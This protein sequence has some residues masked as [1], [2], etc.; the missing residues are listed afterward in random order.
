MPRSFA[1]LLAILPIA[2]LAPARAQASCGWVTSVASWD[3]SLG[4]SWSNG[5]YSWSKPGGE[6]DSATTQDAGS[7][8]GSLAQA[9]PGDTHIVGVMTGSLS[10]FDRLDITPSSGESG[11]TQTVANGP[12]TGGYPLDPPTV[13]LVLDT[14]SCTYTWTFSVGAASTTTTNRGGGYSSTITPNLIQSGEWPI[15]ELPGPLEFDGAIHASTYPPPDNLTPWFNS[16]ANSA[17]IAE[18]N[19]YAPETPLPDASVHWSFRPGTSV[20]PDN[21]GCAGARFLFG[22]ENQDVSFATIAPTDPAST[23]GAGD[24][25]VWFFFLPWNSGT[26]QISTSGSG[27]STVVSVWPV[28][29]TCASLTTEVAC[30]AN[31]A[32]VPVQ[33]GVPLL[34]QVRRSAAGG[35]GSLTIQATPEP[36][37]AAAAGVACGGLA[38]LAHSARRRRRSP[39]PPT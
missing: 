39:R 12:M 34:V 2:L 6:V 32:S 1:L 5:K 28:A 14:L 9:F 38:C 10:F 17:G 20:V 31:G 15:P 7:A 24:R 30:G 27:Y 19:S 8:T 18:S 3:A 37:A 16:I 25:S 21:D 26:A 35:T 4:W 33:Q 29:Q 22:S 36:N 23:C 13:Y 11:F